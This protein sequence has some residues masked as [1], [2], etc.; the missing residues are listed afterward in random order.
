MR[1]DPKALLSTGSGCHNP[2]SHIRK[3]L[4]PQKKAALIVNIRFI[5]FF[6]I[7]K[8]IGFP[9]LP[10]KEAPIMADR[11]KGWIHDH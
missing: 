1:G 11:F 8:T 10:P 4:L 9:C 3:S 2:F 5:S 6:L 7:Y